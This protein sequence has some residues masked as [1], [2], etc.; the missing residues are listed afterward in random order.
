M[1][2]A[3]HAPAPPSA[4]RKWAIGIAVSLGALLEIIDTNIVNVALADIQASVGATLTEVSWLISGYGI[5]NVI[6]LPLAAWFGARFGKKRYFLWSAAG[7][8]IASVLCGVATSFEMLVAARILQG[9]TGG[10]LLAKAQAILF[11]TFPKS[12]QAMAQA[13]FG[14]IVLGGPVIGP[15]LG[16]YIVTHVGW[17]WIFFVNVPLAAI[18]I[19]M[20]AVL[21][22]GDPR[23]RERTPVDW[24]AI[25][26]LAVGLGSLQWVLEEGQTNDW[27][28]S[29]F[30]TVLAVAAVVGIVAFVI[31]ELRSDAP[32]VDLRVFRHRALW[33]GSVLSLVVG[34]VFYAALFS[35][36]LFASSTLHYSSEQI[37]LLLLPGALAS[38][39]AM[40]IAAKLMARIDPR[41]L[42][43]AGGITLLFGM[44]MLIGLSPQTSGDDLF[45]PLIIRTFG[46]VLVFLPL[47]LAALG[48]LPRADIPAATGL[49]NLMRQ[50]GGSMSVALLT[51]LLDQ[52]M[53]FH[54]AILREKIAAADPHIVAR[55]AF[56]SDALIARGASPA[57]AHQTALTLL[58]GR[59]DQQSSVMAFGDSFWVAFV[60]VVVALPLVFLMR[61]PRAE[62]VPIG[63]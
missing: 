46:A 41:A 61:K 22:P 9:L 1:V 37:G 40:P 48:S 12:E 52:R 44:K 62:A 14:A 39:V 42:I 18:A 60:L 35:I 47:Q 43:I 23:N 58:A 45:F 25:A 36:P 26:L 33:S 28:E 4:A 19:V 34:M 31:R 13:L 20:T 24:T 21:L 11:E 16:G 6:I 30:I 49:F 32:V 17:R 10:G 27:F 63:H 54:R 59:V 3:A 51:T 53:T 5:A 7:F 56:G 50:L 2:T 57:A 38:A 29:S 15:T 55:L 8:T